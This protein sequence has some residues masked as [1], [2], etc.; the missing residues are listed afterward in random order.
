MI[1]RSVSVTEEKRIITGL[2]V[3]T[4]FTKEILPVFQ[5]DY[6]INSYLRTIASWG[7]A[8]YEEHERC[9]HV[10]IND[11][12]ES[13]SHT[14]KE[15]DSE[16]IGELLKTLSD[17]YD[18]ETINVDYLKNSAIDYFRKREL[19]IVVNNISVLKEKFAGTLHF[20]RFVS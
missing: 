15:S 5:L 9:P 19:E 17:T 4:Q 12:F 1:E 14:L 10:H 8:F 20:L 18:P 2:I 16:L 13:E 3:S 6:F 7:I 11:I